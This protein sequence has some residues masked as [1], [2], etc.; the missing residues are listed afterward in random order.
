MLKTD[1]ETGDIKPKTDFIAIVTQFT[2]SLT[3]RDRAGCYRL[4]NNTSGR[5]DRGIGRGWG[6]VGWISVSGIRTFL[7]IS[8]LPS[9]SNCLR[10][11]I[12][13]PL[14]WC[15]CHE[16]NQGHVEVKFN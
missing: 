11:V 8:L 16:N 3:T 6:E 5:R 13:H 14:S 7:A 1:F 12:R 9:S 15:R 10:T 2:S 4:Y